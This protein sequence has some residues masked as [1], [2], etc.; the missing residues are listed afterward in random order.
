MKV[1]GGAKQIWVGR[2]LKRDERRERK[3]M[4][5]RKRE[6][7]HSYR[8]DRERIKR[9]DGERIKGKMKRRSENEL[10]DRI[11]PPKAAQKIADADGIWRPVGPRF[12]RRQTQNT[13]L[14]LLIHKSA[15]TLRE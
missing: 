2:V 13:S 11:F 14:V 6:E 12:P 9:I 3:G 10:N 7:I 1:Q 5:S 8:R 4:I 15:K